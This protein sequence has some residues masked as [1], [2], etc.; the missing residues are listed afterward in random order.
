[1]TL[2]ILFPFLL[3][4]IVPNLSTGTVEKR[5]SRMLRMWVITYIVLCGLRD[6]GGADDSSYWMY[7][8]MNYGGGIFSLFGDKEPLFNIFRQ[9]GYLMNANYKW[10]FICYAVFT[11]VVVAFALKKYFEDEPGLAIFIAAMLFLSYSS[12]FTVMRQAAAMA[13]MLL[14]YSKNNLSWKISILFWFAILCCHSGFVIV[15]IIEIVAK[16]INYRTSRI[17]RVAVPMVCFGLGQLLN[18]SSIIEVITTNLGLFSYMTSSANFEK[19]SAIGLVFYVSFAL[20]LVKEWMTYKYEGRLDGEN[21]KKERR[22][23]FGQMMF[24]SL[25]FLTSN[26]RWGNRIGYY[27]TLFIPFIIVDFWKYLPVKGESRRVL[28]LAMKVLLFAGF[29]FVMNAQLGEAGYQW[30]LKFFN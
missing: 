9:L 22:I 26:L 8:E 2:Y 21:L 30:S 1:M 18:L 15:L 11:A 4:F 7:Y 29:I 5:N 10:L 13:L 17:V 23:A 28:S 14:M 6:S 12:M 24:F 16:A 27:Y 19:S 25:L 3:L 20:Y